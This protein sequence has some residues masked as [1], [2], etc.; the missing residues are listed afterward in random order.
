MIS[1]RLRDRMVELIRKNLF[2]SIKYSLSGYLGF[3]VLEIVTYLGLRLLG[4]SRI[5]EIDAVAFFTGVSLEFMVN[6]YWTTRNEGFHES[7][8]RGIFIRLGKFQVL[9]LLGNIIAISI[10]LSLLHFFGIYPLLGNIIGSAMA[11]PFNYIIQMKSV[12]KINVVN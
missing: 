4:Y 11:F 9:N 7:S 1:H 5:V 3:F 8:L 2:R 6:E 12:W 10:Q